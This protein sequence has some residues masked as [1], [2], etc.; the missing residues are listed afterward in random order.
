MNIKKILVLFLVAIIGIIAPVNSALFGSLYPL[1][2]TN[3]KNTKLTW[4]IWSNI[5][6]YE[7]NWDSANYVSKRKAEVNRVNKVV[8]SIKGQTAVTIK[9]PV[10]GWK[11]NKN[12]ELTNTFTIKSNH[13]TL[14]GKN[15]TFKMYDNKGKLLKNMNPTK[16]KLYYSRPE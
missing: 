3:S 16:G 11:T 6:S 10:K 14:N 1:S 7:D 2:E 5:G 9:K 13:K 8:V 4:N 15:Y 12:G